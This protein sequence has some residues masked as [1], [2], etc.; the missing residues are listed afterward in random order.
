MTHPR[1]LLAIALAL[2]AASPVV[3]QRGSIHASQQRELGPSV[4]APSDDEEEMEA[5]TVGSSGAVQAPGA[6]A[7]TVSPVPT[8]VRAAR[9]ADDAVV[10]GY[11]QSET[12]VYHLRWHA[13]THVGSRFVGFDGDGRLTGTAAFTGRS[14]YLRA[15]G[16]AEAAGVRFVLVL[17]NFDDDPGG[18]IER[19]MTSA[20]RRATLISELV[21][22]IAADSYCQG[23]SLDLEFSWG[24][25]VR[26]GITAFC[27]ELK[28][29]L[30]T[31]GPDME[32]S[33]Y[34]NAILS[35]SQ[36]DFDA[37]TGVTPHIDFMLYS[38]YDWASGL[39]ARAISDLDNC[40]GASRMPAYLEE[41]LP[42]EKLVP[43]ISAY[44]RRW[45]GAG[46][47]GAAGT[48]SQSSGFTDALFDVTLMPG[49]GPPA[50]R[51]VRGDEAG[52]YTWGSGTPTTR[53]FESPEALEVEVMN[54]LSFQGASG[55]W[56]GRRLGGVGFWS[57]MWMS[58]FSSVD[59]RTGATVARTRTYPHIYQLVHDA[60]AE[61]G[62]P[63]RCLERFDGLDPRWRDPNESPDT[64]GDLDLD[65]RR[66]L[67]ATGPGTTG[68]GLR[69]TAD[70]EGA[71]RAVFAHEVL[72]SPLAPGLA[73][74]NSALGRIPW[75]SEL[76]L[77]YDVTAPAAGARLRL[78]VIDARGQVE[79]SRAFPLDRP[80]QRTARWQLDIAAATWPVQTAEPAFTSGNGV[81]DA[82]GSV[83]QD[84]G[85]LGVV[86]ETDGAAR[87]EVTLDE[88]AYRA[89]DP[90][91]RRYRINEVRPG[92]A[93]QEFVELHGPAGPLPPGLALRTYDRTDGSVQ[94][95][96]QLMGAIADDGGGRGLLVV[97]DAGV[98]ELDLT[99]G[100]S[101]GSDDLS[102]LSPLGVQLV[103]ILTG[104]VHDSVVM[105]ALGGIQQLARPQ[106]GGVAR[107][108]G[109]WCGDVGPGTDEA[110]EP[111]SLARRIDGVDT[112]HNH[113]D[114]CVSPA[115]PGRPNRVPLPLPA[116]LDFEAPS[117]FLFQSFSAPERRD[118]NLSG[119]PS[120][121]D[122][123]RAW[124]V[125]DPA[126]GGVIGR[127]S[128]T[129][130]GAQGAH[131]V[132]G[133]LYVPRSID[134]AQAIG[135]GLC[136]QHGS[137]FFPQD[138][139]SNGY[140]SGYWLTYENR[141]GVGLADGLPDRPGVWTFMFASHD[142]ADGAVA[143]ELNSLPGFFL[144]AVEGQWS[145][146][147][148]TLDPS[149]PP[150]RQLIATVNGQDLYRGPVPAGGP[151]VGAFQVGF[152]ENHV[153]PPSL[154][155]GT[156]VDGVEIEGW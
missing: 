10:F 42:P 130:L 93:A 62:N 57:L 8:T 56:G 111:G 125:V 96:F 33:I 21:Q 18:D 6:P 7:R 72:A 41:G 4:H 76:A 43:V 123:G 119:M 68:R 37:V 97:G 9:L 131:R 50:L 79:A 32:L 47:Y 101:P 86:V 148:L 59:P 146:F 90:G 117:P 51:H 155:E 99:S 129:S 143:V 91:G 89:G 71:G 95:E 53:T 39:T 104:H 52:W 23:V 63:W 27:R 106:T 83:H 29:A 38:M 98:A 126:G 66:D 15:G 49:V 80:G 55:A 14:S 84:I 140:E 147:E 92:G 73:D 60:F 113:S 102:N 137:H 124:R 107:E 75:S 78:L 69:L 25:Q 85:V 103:D 115:T 109:P 65:S 3:A 120:S 156:W 139:R 46:A 5:L 48:S 142:G 74:T 61:S 133:D 152:R 144:A 11:L 67:V 77:T 138:P 45:T 82:A 114:F 110:G 20:T 17:A 40:L 122:G 81:V 30:T 154:I 150:S 141:A 44:S 2:Q 64:T 145:R 149:A 19:V 134:P 58:E 54:A 35:T 127:V 153:G 118:P 128:D 116:R 87:V 13:L 36:W 105:R 135:V 132:R 34:T 31:L 1:T 121:P 16:A 28:G 100:F 151:R 26:D 108:G 94:R 22:V 70:L 12:Q 112:D 24:P 136:G 88:I